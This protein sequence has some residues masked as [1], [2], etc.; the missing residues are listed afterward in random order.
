MATTQTWCWRKW[1][2]YNSHLLGTNGLL[3]GGHSKDHYNRV[4]SWSGRWTNGLCW[5]VEKHFI[6]DDIS[7]GF[8]RK[9]ECSVV[10]K[11]MYNLEH[12]HLLATLNLNYIW[13]IDNYISI[14]SCHQYNG[15]K[16]HFQLDYHQICFCF[17]SGKML[18]VGSLTGFEILTLLC[19][20][21]Y[22]VSLG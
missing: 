6:E 22:M 7:C 1:I 3:R 12:H 19:H 11:W 15:I 16:K 14:L 10:W 5:L 21:A 2:R 13:I 18:H 4:C 8:W 20:A 9:N 17:Y